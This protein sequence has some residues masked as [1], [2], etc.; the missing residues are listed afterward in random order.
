MQNVLFVSIILFSFGINAQQLSI[1]PTIINF[2]LN[3]PGSVETQTINITNKSQKVQSIQANFGDWDRNEDGSHEY[4][5]AG[6][7]KNSCAKWASLN[8]TLLDI[9]PGETAQLVLSLKAPDSPEEL[10]RMKWAMLF[11]QGAKIKEPEAEVVGKVS[12]RINEV[13]RMGLHIYQTP[14]RLDLRSAVVHELHQSEKDNKA[15]DLLVE[16][17]GQVMVRTKSYLE[18][19][20][21]STGEEFRTNLEETPIFPLGKRKV[22]LHLPENLPTGKYSMLAIMDYGDPNKLEAIERIVEIN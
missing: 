7:H 21:M 20:N 16:N 15:Y 6:T 12:T 10:M 14:G 5:E 9:A 17:N 1:Y 8:T 22:S 11:I 3:E 18:L 13:V 4:L 2:Q 19:V